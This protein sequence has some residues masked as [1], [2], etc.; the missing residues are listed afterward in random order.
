MKNK[1]PRPNK[2]KKRY[3]FALHVHL[4][5]IYRV[6]T[7]SE[8]SKTQNRLIIWGLCSE[9]EVAY[10]KSWIKSRGTAALCVTKA[11]T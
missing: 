10:I 1:Q 5:Y 2:C 9:Y 4:I 6:D 11:V 7:G 8:V 3:D